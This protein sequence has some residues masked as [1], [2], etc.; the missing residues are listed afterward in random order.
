MRKII[1][2]TYLSLD[3]VIGRPEVWTTPYFGEEAAAYA[4]E[5]L[6]SCDALIAGRVT[7]E[8][9]AGVWPSMEEQT[10]DFGVRMNTLPKYLVSTTLDKAGWGETEIISADVPERVAEIRN[11]E[12]G[13]IL[14]YGFGRLSRTLVEHG[15]LDELRLWIHPVFAGTGPAESMIGTPDF[16]ASFTLADV[17]PF[18]SGVIVATYV[19]SRK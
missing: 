10:G 3:G 5:T 18:T 8:A 7:Y 14:Q 19:P 15:L 4:R 13:D 9:F 11:G 6:F 12:G 1:N 2:S 16:T 17:K